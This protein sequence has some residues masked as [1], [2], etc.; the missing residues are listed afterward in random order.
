MINF[1]MFTWGIGSDEL[2][3]FNGG[4][5]LEFNNPSSSSYIN[6]NNDN[7]NTNNISNTSNNC[8]TEGGKQNES[9]VILPDSTSNSSLNNDNFKSNSIHKSNN[10]NRFINKFTSLFN[11][12]YWRSITV[13]LINIIVVLISK[14]G[15]LYFLLSP[16]YSFNLKLVMNFVLSM[17]DLGID[18]FYHYHIIHFFILFI[19]IL[20]NLL[21][22]CILYFFLIFFIFN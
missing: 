3:N 22:F 6:E 12:V 8:I 4:R 21:L 9:T 18:L 5:D 11:I 14:A 16:D 2:N 13:V 20:F 1:G 15:I 17:F 7:N 10:K 19:S